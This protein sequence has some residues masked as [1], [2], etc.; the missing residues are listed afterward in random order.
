[1]NHESPFQQTIRHA[2]ECQGVGLHSGQPSDMTVEPASPGHGIIFERSDLE[3]KP[4]I[5]ATSSCVVDTFMC[6]R[7]GNPQGVTVATIEHLMAALA[8]CGID[9]A[10]IKLQGPEIPFMDGSSLPFIDMIESTGI[11]QQSAPRRILCVLKDIRVGGEGRE[12]RFVQ[13]SPADRFSARIT[14]DFGGRQGMGRYAYHFTGGREAFKRDI[15]PARSFGF[16][17][18]AQKLY[19]KGLSLGA[20]LDNT[21]VIDQGKVMN[22]SGVRFE[23]EYVR[24]K[25]LDAIGDLYLAGAPLQAVYTAHNPGHEGHHKLLKA[26]FADPSAWRY[27]EQT[28]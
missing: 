12:D 21:V 22:P 15:A 10:L 28:P 7:L 17:E 18:D 20:S 16:Y 3:G 25:I 13:L 8:A 4:K 6:T 9:N 14:F 27:E 5:H 24:H 1:M 26:L 2:F 11:V 19:D 23:D